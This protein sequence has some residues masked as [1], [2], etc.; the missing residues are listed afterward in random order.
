MFSA[1]GGSCRARATKMYDETSPGRMLTNTGEARRPSSSIERRARSAP[2]VVIGSQTTAVS[3]ATTAGDRSS[4]MRPR[5]IHPAA[6]ARITTTRHPIVR[7]MRIL[8]S[9]QRRATHHAVSRA[10]IHGLTHHQVHRLGHRL[11]MEIHR[12]RGRRET[13]RADLARVDPADRH[14]RAVC[15][16]LDLVA[17]RL[18]RALNVVLQQL[19]LR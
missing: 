19:E 7:M 15:T 12:A 5:S 2:S 17:K 9:A 6:A 13:R 4:P 1:D 14:V 16:A 11:R 10:T 3:P 8:V 18:A